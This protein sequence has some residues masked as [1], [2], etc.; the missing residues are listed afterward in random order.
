[1]QTWAKSMV[2]GLDI[3]I[4]S[5]YEA[6]PAQS[7]SLSHGGTQEATAQNCQHSLPC[8]LFPSSIL[9]GWLL[10]IFVDLLTP[11]IAL[12]F[13]RLLSFLTL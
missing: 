11:L 13:P 2:Q 6:Q 1:M 8:Q 5:D 3:T 4:Q 9:V 7:H 12:L 10:L